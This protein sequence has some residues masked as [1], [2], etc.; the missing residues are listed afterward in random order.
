M[1]IATEEFF[2]VIDS[3]CCLTGLD[4]GLNT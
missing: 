2:S 4:L 3:Y 1:R